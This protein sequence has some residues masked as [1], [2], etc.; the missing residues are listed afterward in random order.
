MIQGLADNCDSPEE[1]E[2]LEQFFTGG[3]RRLTLQNVGHFPHREAPQ[4]VAEAILLHFDEKARPKV[5]KA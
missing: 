1:S 5:R 3:Y 2:G 4:L